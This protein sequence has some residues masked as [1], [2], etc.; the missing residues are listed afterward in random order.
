[1]S[2]IDSDVQTFLGGEENQTTERKTESYV[3]SCFGNGIFQ[4]E[5]ENRQLEDL[6]QADFGYVPERFLLSVTTK[7]INEN[8]VYRKLRPSFGFVLFQRIFLTWP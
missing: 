5:K 3:F 6:P 4:A 7:S 1:M 8:F 2:L